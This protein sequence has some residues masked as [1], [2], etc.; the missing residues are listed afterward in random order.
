M[1]LYQCEQM[2]QYKKQPLVLPPIS[3][4]EWIKLKLQD[5]MAQNI[6]LWLIGKRKRVSNFEGDYKR[7][8]MNI[9]RTSDHRLKVVKKAAKN[10][11]SN[12]P[13]DNDAYLLLFKVL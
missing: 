13:I 5:R 7:L 10:Q 3:Q 2:L 12:K 1:N 11:L 4:K 8:R 9:K 6:F